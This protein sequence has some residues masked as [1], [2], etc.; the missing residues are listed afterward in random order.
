MND[1]RITTGRPSSSAGHR[2]GQRT[3]DPAVRRLRPHRRNDFLEA[4]AVFAA[5]NRLDVGADQLNLVPL[6][7]PRVVQRDR[8]VERR[9]AP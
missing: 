8:A 9:L 3:A 6:Q 4:L 5:L 2:R 7:H 1:G